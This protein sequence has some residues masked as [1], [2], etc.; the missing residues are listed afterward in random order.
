MV[1]FFHILQNV[2]LLI[3]NPN[4]VVKGG[5]KIVKIGIVEWVFSFGKMFEKGLNHFP[6]KFQD[7]NV[8][9]IIPRNQHQVS[10][11]T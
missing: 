7:L 11:K 4:F 2:S 1:N 6:A 8:F 5:T 9:L 3:F 10:Q